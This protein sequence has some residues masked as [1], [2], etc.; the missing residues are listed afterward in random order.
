MVE[1]RHG[2]AGPRTFGELAATNLLRRDATC[3]D[4]RRARH[5]LKYSARHYLCGEC[6]DPRRDELLPKIAKREA[7]ARSRARQI[8]NFFRDPDTGL[9][10]APTHAE[11]TQEARSIDLITKCGEVYAA[12]CLQ[13][14]LSRRVTSAK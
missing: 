14:A 3:S 4:C 12:E 10:R 1:L 8:V 7:R 6:L 13:S 5:C 11:L 9:G 2:A